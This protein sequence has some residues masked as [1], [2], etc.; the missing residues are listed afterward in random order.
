MAIAIGVGAIAGEV[1]KHGGAALELWVGSVNT[2]VDNVRAGT[3]TGT[4]VIGV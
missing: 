3:G 2:C 4:A 1:G